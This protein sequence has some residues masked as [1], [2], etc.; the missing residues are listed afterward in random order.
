MADF[1]RRVYGK[2]DRR[3]AA[4]LIAWTPGPEQVFRPT[5]STVTRGRIHDGR[6][7]GYSGAPCQRSPGG[8]RAL[9][10]RFSSAPVWL[11]C[12]NAQSRRTRRREF[13]SRSASPAACTSVR[14]RSR[15]RRRRRPD[16]DQPQ[17][18]AAVRAAP[19]PASASDVR[20]RGS[21]ASASRP[22]R[23]NRRERVHHRR[24]ADRWSTTS[25]PARSRAVSSIPFVL[26]GAGLL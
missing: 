8:E 4:K 7:T 10:W 5:P 13:S 21:K 3:R 19:G 26:A 6:Q 9:H 25:C 2:T 14:R 22:R 18:R 24:R 16:A 1:S 23:A 17:E 11:Q 15:A 12:A 20:D